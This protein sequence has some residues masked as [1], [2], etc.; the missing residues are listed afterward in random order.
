MHMERKPRR[1]TLK[2]HVK[3]EMT[4]SLGGK[5]GK[6]SAV[7]YSLTLNNT[8]RNSFLIHKVF[9]LWPMYVSEQHFLTLLAVYSPPS[10]ALIRRSPNCAAWRT[11]QV[12]DLPSD[13]VHECAQRLRASGVMQSHANFLFR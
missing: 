1:E 7:G 6:C 3:H 12:L 10:F 13:S 9:Y 2:V 11:I 5:K 8:R 4:D